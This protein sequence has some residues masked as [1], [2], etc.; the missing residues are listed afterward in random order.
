MEFARRL[1]VSERTGMSVVSH[2]GDVFA[3]QK[4][5]SRSVHGCT[6]PDR[7]FSKGLRKAIYRMPL[8]KLPDADGN[9]LAFKFAAL[10]ENLYRADFSERFNPKP[11]DAAD[12]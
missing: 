10:C 12:E 8:L 1:V 3:P 7:L 9:G 4:L 5:A 11:A 2:N 6:L